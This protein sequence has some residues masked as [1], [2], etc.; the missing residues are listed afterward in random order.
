VAK[1]IEKRYMKFDD[2][3]EKYAWHGDARYKFEAVSLRFAANNSLT[4]KIID[5]YSKKEIRLVATPEEVRKKVTEMNKDEF[6][7][8]KR[9]YDLCFVKYKK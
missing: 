4:Y 6:A 8:L 5:R 2:F 3:I 9:I 1:Q 7:H